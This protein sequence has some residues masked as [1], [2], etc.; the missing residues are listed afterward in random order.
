MSPDDGSPTDHV[1]GHSDVHQDGDALRPSA[2]FP[3]E[4]IG[5]IQQMATTGRYEIRG[6]GAKRRVPNFDDLVFLTAAAS[7]YPLE[8]YR[9]RCDTSTVLG[10]RYASRPLELDIPITIAGMSFGSLSAHA[11]E[12]LGRAATAVGTSTTTGDGGMT[13]EERKASKWLVYQCLPSR[14]GFNPHD[15]MQAD[16]IEI[17]I[18]QGA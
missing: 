8:G 10:S 9:E 11:K 1:L 12:A 15:L 18:G 5:Q 14:Y 17:V 4:V 16:A 13:A 2:T 7:R 3:A 6:W